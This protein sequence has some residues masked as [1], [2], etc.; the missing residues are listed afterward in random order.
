MIVCV[1]RQQP[2]GEEK[3]GESDSTGNEPVEIPPE[4]EPSADDIDVDKP[5]V[6][7]ERQEVQTTTVSGSQPVGRR[8]NSGP[9]VGVATVS[10]KTVS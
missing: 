1:C 9:S 5:Q 3:K 4:S 2:D 6:K 7:A 8:I 10:E